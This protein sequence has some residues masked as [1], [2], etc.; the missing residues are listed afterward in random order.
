LTSKDLIFHRLDNQQIGVPRFTAP[1]DLVRWMGCIQAQD[2]AGAKWALGNR[3]KGITDA[4]IEKDFSDGKILR[5]H[6][7][8]PTWHFVAPEDIR[9]ILQFSAP[10]LKAFNKG[11]HRKLGIDD[12]VLRQ[13]KKIIAR[14][15]AGG[16]QLTRAELAIFLQKK[17][18][19]T[20]DIRLA[21][22]MMDAELDGIICSGPRKGKQFTYALLEHRVT[23]LRATD[24]AMA[25]GELAKRYFASRGPATLPDFAWWGGMNLSDA[26]KGIEICK[27]ELVHES[28][29]GQVHWFAE[30]VHVTRSPRSIPSIHLL[31][32]FDEYAI[33]YTDRSAILPEQHRKVTGS[34]IFKPLIL[35]E[36]RIAGTWRRT[37]HKDKVTLET[38]PLGSFSKAD[39][40]SLHLAAEDYAR[41]LGK[42]LILAPQ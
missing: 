22:L 5:T 11:S 28:I 41:F 10:R 9:W 29:N 24:R 6:I 21:Y 31:P 17:K 39:K 4:A 8:R 35:K 18:I 20:D 38:A 27:N 40:R 19:D 32:A 33:A 15:L 37:E 2:F 30:S 13:S 42:D 1:D 26:K 3:V 14:A 25:I 12:A 7:L 34:G 36:G 16:Q 23:S